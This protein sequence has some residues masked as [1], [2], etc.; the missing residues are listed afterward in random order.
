M[1]IP[2]DKAALIAALLCVGI[3]TSGLRASR[4]LCAVTGAII[5]ILLYGGKP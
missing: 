1:P 4:T 3:A 2:M 5:L